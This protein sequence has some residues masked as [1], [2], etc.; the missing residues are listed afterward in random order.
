MAIEGAKGIFLVVDARPTKNHTNPHNVAKNNDT[1]AK[2]KPSTAPITAYNFTSP[3][4][5]PPCDSHA[6]NAKNKKM[7]ALPTIRMN[8]SSGSNKQ[9]I[10]ITLPKNNKIRLGIS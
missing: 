5:I 7:L 1:N 9:M 4:P 8:N 6:N 2:G 3:P 10:K